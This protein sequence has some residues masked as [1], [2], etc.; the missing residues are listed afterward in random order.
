[1]REEDGSALPHRSAATQAVHQVAEAIQ[2]HNKER[3]CV[4]RRI[5]T[6][7]RHL[8]SRR[9]QRPE[10]ELPATHPSHNCHTANPGE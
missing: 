3:T 7:C 5:R 9:E 4:A 1:M 10:G 2:A 6:P 8:A